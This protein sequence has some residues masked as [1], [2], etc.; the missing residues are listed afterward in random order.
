MWHVSCVAMLLSCAVSKSFRVTRKEGNVSE[1]MLLTVSSIR[2]RKTSS[3]E[4]KAR[5]VTEFICNTPNEEG[6]RGR[7]IFG[8]RKWLYVAVTTGCCGIEKVR[9][10]S[11]EERERLGELVNSTSKF[12]TNQLIWT[13]PGHHVRKKCL[14]GEDNFV[15]S[16]VPSEFNQAFLCYHRNGPL[17][18]WYL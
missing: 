10:F 14:V 11:Y 15:N 4:I 9:K 8:K 7:G 12:M 1:D 2:H 17:E 16:D 18:D 6:G 3:I 13:L 5:L